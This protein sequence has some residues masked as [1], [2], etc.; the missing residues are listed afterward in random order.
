[1]WRPP[2]V[3]EE[4]CVYRFWL[5]KNEYN[6]IEI[7]MDFTDKLA[8]GERTYRRPKDRQRTRKYASAS[9]TQASDF[10]SDS[11]SGSLPVD[12]GVPDALMPM[13]CVENAKGVE[14]ETDT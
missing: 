3:E 14:P 9:A 5:I 10:T 7:A 6:I 8:I 12:G 1:M 11:L 13:S 4:H 2:D